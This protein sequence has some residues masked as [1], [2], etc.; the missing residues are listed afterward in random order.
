MIDLYYWPTPN[1]HKITIFLEEAGLPY[2]IVPVDI[3][4]G[5]QFQPAFLAI[6]PNNKMP[7]IVDPEGP[8]GAPL[9]VFESGAMLLYLADKTGRFLPADARG[10]SAVV[11]WVMWQ[12]AGQGPML[13]QA[14]HSIL[15]LET[16]N[17]SMFGNSELSGDHVEYYHAMVA[18]SS[19][20][21]IIFAASRRQ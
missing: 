2:R 16:F 9:S 3:R 20:R 8:G 14:G 21:E 4:G 15:E 17:Y 19:L 18:D 11:E 10:R 7:A 12:M 6:S 13:G 1:G 5:D